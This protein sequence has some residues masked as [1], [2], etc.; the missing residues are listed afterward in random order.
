[1]KL[2]IIGDIISNDDKWVY[3]WLGLDSIC[4]KDVH[5]VIEKANGERLDVWINSGGGDLFSGSEM[6]EALRAYPGT[7]NV[8]I[9]LA[10]SAATLPACAGKSEIAPTGMYMIHNVASAA[11]GDYHAMDKSSE[12]L[13]KANRAVCAAYMDKTGKTEAELLKLMD[14]ET[15]YTAREAVD[16]GL[17]DAISTE[18][19]RLVDSGPG[20]IPHKVIDH[21]K[22]EIKNPFKLRAARAA[23]AKLDFLKL[24]GEEK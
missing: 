5:N 16:A 17:V 10:A 2:N 23:Q 24:R 1:M 19:Q 3:D 15:W 6:Y 8:H 18:T 21:I 4:P 13:Q 20:T 12:I 14:R 7:V 9:V 22:S 11:R